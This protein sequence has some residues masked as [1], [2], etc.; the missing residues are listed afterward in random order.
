MAAASRDGTVTTWLLGAPAAAENGPAAAAA[1]GEGER[2]VAPQELTA[3]E[4]AAA[5]T[6]AAAF[7][8]VAAA[9]ADD[10]EGAEAS[11]DAPG[12]ATLAAAPSAERA[13]ADASAS[14][15]QGAA[16]GAGDVAAAALGVAP[17]PP[18][19]RGP[20]HFLRGCPEAPAAVAVS[21]SLDCV[22][23]ACPTAGLALFS[24]LRGRLTRR[25]PGA[26]G[27]LLALSREGY[28]AVWDPRARLLRSVSL[29]GALAAQAAP[30]GDEGPLA[31]MVV[32]ADG[33]TLVTGSA[34]DPAHPG[35]VGRV[36]LRAMPTLRELY[37]FAV[38]EGAAVTSL[39]L[40]EGDTL[41]LVATSGGATLV[42][43]DPQAPPPR[44]MWAQAARTL[45][46]KLPMQY[47]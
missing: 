44:P 26:P 15:A 38:P 3:A 46:K 39:L 35:S 20:L 14:A 10:E 41:L 37:R 24:L 16:Q 34:P 11:D 23:A 25:V 43:T 9:E 13:E 45:A 12:A 7:A 19:L 2:P 36:T 1:E 28:A 40:L 5:A 33:R 22:A 6:A 32:S 30:P 31:A 47:D 17:P 27:E 29:N 42:I 4:H 18:P 21:C 8:A